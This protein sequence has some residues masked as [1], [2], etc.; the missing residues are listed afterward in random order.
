MILPVLVYEFVC[1]QI[2]F[3]CYGWIWIG[4]FQEMCEMG[5]GTNGLIFRVIRINVWICVLFFFLLC[6]PHPLLLHCGPHP[7]LL[8]CGPHLLV[9]VQ[10]VPD[11]G[12]A[13]R[14]R[15]PHRLALPEVCGEGAAAGAFLQDR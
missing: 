1:V 2:N 8:L 3:K 11:K 12:C 7:L 13:G 4:H 15:G 10:D 6:G 14:D 5:K 9:L